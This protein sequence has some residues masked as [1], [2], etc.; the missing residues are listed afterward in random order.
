M[1]KCSNIF[2][3][4]KETRSGIRRRGRI[5]SI[6]PPQLNTTIES[7]ME[8]KIVVAVINAIIR[9]FLFVILPLRRKNVAIAIVNTLE[10]NKLKIGC[11]FCVIIS[12]IPPYSA[13]FRYAR[14]SFEI[15]SV[16][17]LA[18]AVPR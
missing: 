16:L 8:H 5:I 15:D 18:P 17:T 1:K 13:P 4:N 3:P 10:N 14:M 12:I 11:Q 6:P 7:A 2:Y 9:R